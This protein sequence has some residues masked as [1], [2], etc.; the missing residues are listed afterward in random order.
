MAENNI[1]ETYYSWEAELEKEYNR[2]FFDAQYTIFDGIISPRD[3]FN[4]PIKVLFLNREAY[5]EDECSYMIHHALRK[6]IEKGDPIFNNTYWINQNM[7]ERLAFCSLLERITDWQDD[8][9]IEYA[10]NMNDNEYRSLLLKSAYCNIKKSDGVNGSSKNNLL[11]YAQKGWSII[12]KQICF[13]NPTLIIGGNVID[14]IIECVDG[15]TWGEELYVS[16][17][18][19]G[20]IYL[21]QFGGKFYPI[22]DLYHPSYT[23]HSEDL[24]YA[25]KQST[26]IHPGYWEKRIGQN[27]FDL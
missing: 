3:Y 5:D 24:Y 25:L 1:E 23:V 12:E 22:I 14:D 17:E 16:L 19:K 18:T 20:T 21:I 6:Q 26:L 9:A 27:C 8:E 4:S 7:K 2:I 10:Q 13:F 11:E 15:L